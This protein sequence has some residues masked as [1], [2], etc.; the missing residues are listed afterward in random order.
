MNVTEINK[1]IKLKAKHDLLAEILK[2]AKKNRSQKYREG[3]KYTTQYGHHINSETDKGKPYLAIHGM[4]Q[5]G[6][7][8][9]LDYKIKEYAVEYRALSIALAFLYNKRFD[10]IEKFWY[11]YSM[12]DLL[13]KKIMTYAN[14]NTSYYSVYGDRYGRQAQAINHAK[15]LLG[16]FKYEPVYSPYSKKFSHNNTIYVNDEEFN[17]WIKVTSNKFFNEDVGPI[18]L[19]HELELHRDSLS[20]KDLHPI[21]QWTKEVNTVI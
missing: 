1:A 19:T 7:A 18:S 20:G 8:G 21:V 2:D 11:N 13:T 14:M 5:E 3:R 6:I 17:E 10:G 15:V 9:Y 4:K 12:S 16:M